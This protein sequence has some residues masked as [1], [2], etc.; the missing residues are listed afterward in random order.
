MVR[1]TARFGCGIPEAVATRIGSRVDVIARVR[2]GT[3]TMPCAA[4]LAVLD[5]LVRVEIGGLDLVRYTVSARVAGH[6][7]AAT[8]EVTPVGP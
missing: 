2:P 4:S 5:Q 6:D 3:E 7:G 1:A 8:F